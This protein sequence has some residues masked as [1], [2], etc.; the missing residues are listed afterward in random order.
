M[1]TMRAQRWI[2]LALLT[3]A[4]SNAK[5]GD[6]APVVDLPDYRIGIE[7]VLDIAVW[8]VNELQKT[9][10]VRPDGKIS[11][12]LVNDVVAA[13]LTPMQLREQLTKTL[14]T[15]VHDPDVSVV[16][17]EIRS[18]KVAV[19]GQ[20][21]SPGRY[22]IKG[23]STVL[24]ALALAGGLTEFAGRRKIMVV[25]AGGGK[26]ER[27]RFDYDAAVSKGTADNNILVK[28]GDVVVVP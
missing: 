24:D 3:C 23:P 1:R 13:G 18:L 2:L 25:R 11:F 21:K 28:A 9:V 15:Y 8:N 5:A 14:A 20:V 4:V 26:V 19:I 7:D 10:P 22:D 12:P 27:L 6:H 17:R 16:V